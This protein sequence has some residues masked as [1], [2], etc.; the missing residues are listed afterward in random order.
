MSVRGAIRAAPR[1]GPADP[2]R[3]SWNMGQLGCLVFVQGRATFDLHK[4][5]QVRCVRGAFRVVHARGVPRFF[6]PYFPGVPQAPS[7][8]CPLLSVRLLSQSLRCDDTRGVSRM[9]L[10][11]PAFFFPLFLPS[12]PHL[13]TPHL[14]PMIDA[15]T[16]SMSKRMSLAVNAVALASP[17]TM[18]S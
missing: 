10:G 12:P 9:V 2:R 4:V 7:P 15:R 18:Y 1:A 6:F 8:S 13:L 17:S 5:D 3:P 11:C 14:H 16:I